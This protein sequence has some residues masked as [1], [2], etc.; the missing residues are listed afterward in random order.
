MFSTRTLTQEQLLELTQLVKDAVIPEGQELEIYKKR[1]PVVTVKEKTWMLRHATT[2]ALSIWNNTELV[3][4][5]TN[6]TKEDKDKLSS[7][8]TVT[9]PVGGRCKD[10]KDGFTQKT[11]VFLLQNSTQGGKSIMDYKEYSFDEGTVLEY[12]GSKLTHGV[13]EVKEGLRKTLVVMYWSKPAIKS[14]I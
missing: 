1:V 9:Y 12:N 2:Q 6:F 8:H 13:T 10:H 11:F 7:I 4:W 3:D 14:T 5:I